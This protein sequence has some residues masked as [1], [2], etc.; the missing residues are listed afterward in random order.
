MRA[1]IAWTLKYWLWL[2]LATSVAMLAITHAFQTF[3]GL[4]PCTLC[5][6][7]REVYWVA[8][9]LSAAA[10]VVRAV[11]RV[12]RLAPL[13]GAVLALTFLTGAVIAAYH[14]GAEWK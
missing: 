5:L 12:R 11:P 14:A 10:L 1:L 13:V 6:R 2:A 4:E 7:Q 8:L 9:C 3:G